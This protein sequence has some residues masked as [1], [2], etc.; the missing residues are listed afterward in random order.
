MVV[1]LRLHFLAHPVYLPIRT[2]SDTHMAAA[3]SNGEM[4]RWH[5]RGDIDIAR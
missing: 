2:K 3:K 4:S 5:E 1:S